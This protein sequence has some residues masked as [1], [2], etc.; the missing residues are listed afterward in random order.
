MTLL[1]G[2]YEIKFDYA[3]RKNFPAE[4]SSFIV[5]FNGVLIATIRPDLYGVTTVQLTVEGR[6]GPNTLQFVD[7]G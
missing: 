7:N 3:P 4:E 5:Y 6:N 2:K 1:Q